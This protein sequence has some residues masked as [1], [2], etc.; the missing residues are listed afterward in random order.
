MGHPSLP[1]NDAPC[2]VWVPADHRMLG[3][4]ASAT[5]FH[6]VA[7]EYS[8]ALLGC[9][10]VRP[11]MFPLVEPAEVPA[12]LELVDGVLLTGS[13]SN[14][15][16]SH[17][18]EVVADPALPLDPRRDA[19]NFALVRA[20]MAQGVPLLGICRGLQE[21]NVALG[22]SL[23]QRVHAVPGRLDHREP[24]GQPLEVMF[25]PAHAV[26]FVPGS[27]FARWAGGSEAQVNSLHGQGIARLAEGLEALG[28]APDG[29][30]EAVA[31]RGARS[32]AFAVQ[33]HPEWDCQTHALDGALFR[34]FGDAC[35]ARQDQRRQQRAKPSPMEMKTATTSDKGVLP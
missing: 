21:I 28:Q 17:F 19:L 1:T 12:L 29:Q 35:R 24:H 16:P 23:H 4:G 15:H 31:I 7:D 13:P 33:W 27:V 26:H 18:G 25:A 11:V 3:K 9:A 6:V 20:C 30:V 34:A 8:Q 5:P 22:G 10:A 2:L 32:F 14:V